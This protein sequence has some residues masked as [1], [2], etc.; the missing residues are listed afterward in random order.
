MTR[1]PEM[2]PAALDNEQLDSRGYAL[3]QWLSRVFHPLLLNILIFYL[4]GLFA[5]ATYRE[6]LLWATICVLVQ[7]LPGSTFFLLRQ[8]SGAYSDR[9]VSDR[10]QRHE[11]YLF[12]LVSLLVGVLV[13]PWF[14]MPRP[15]FDLLLA[16]LIIGA[17]NGFVNIF[18]KISAHAT[19]VATLATVAL[20]YSYSLGLTLWVCALVVGWARVRTRNHTP[21]QVLAGF[22]VAAGV[23]LAVFGIVR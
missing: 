11:L 22:G 12:G 17:V 4:V 8:R 18:W 23:V 1:Q 20:F 19:S 7:V 15:F 13:L 6:G 9:D 16:G 21:T 2:R 10:R 3:A 5:S 14:G